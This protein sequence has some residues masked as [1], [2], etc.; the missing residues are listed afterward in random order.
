[1]VEIGLGKA[2]D[3]IRIINISEKDIWTFLQPSRIMKFYR[4]HIENLSGASKALLSVKSSVVKL[5]TDSHCFL[6]F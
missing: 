2:F 3:E 4:K 1:M 5:Y 6:E